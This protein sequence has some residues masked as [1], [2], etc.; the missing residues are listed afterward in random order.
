MNK[1]FTKREENFICEK[2]GESVTGNGYTN[3]CPK[4]LWGKHVDVNPGDRLAT[5]GGLMEPI[6][7]EMRKGGEFRLL[8]KCQACGILRKNIMAKND[9]MELVFSIERAR[10]GS[11]GKLPTGR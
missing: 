9:N 11:D 1:R 2:C 6:G 3:H 10:N 5:C 4:C 8:E 7:V